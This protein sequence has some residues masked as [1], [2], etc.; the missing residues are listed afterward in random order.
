MTNKRYLTAALALV[1]SGCAA[2]VGV[3]AEA[4]LGAF[5]DWDTN[6]DAFVDETEFGVGFNDAG[7]FDDWDT[8][9]DG[10]LSDDEFGV[11]AGNLG[12][13]DDDFGEWDVNDD[14]GLSEDEFGDGVFD[15]WD[16]DDDDR[17]AGAE[18]EAGIGLFD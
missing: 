10:I 9:D 8:D 15:T 6:R 18:F 16:D 17:I 3:G 4:D 13:D 11:G 1:L 12:L 14:S 7:V 2:G 5:N